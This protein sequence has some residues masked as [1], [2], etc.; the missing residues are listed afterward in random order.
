LARPIST[1]DDRR[2]AKRIACVSVLHRWWN[3]SLEPEA[4]REEHARGAATAADTDVI[5]TVGIA[6]IFSAREVALQGYFPML[7]GG[8]KL[9]AAVDAGASR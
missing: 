7:E 4:A 6:G 5:A 3:V 9:S 1:R 2:D 8:R